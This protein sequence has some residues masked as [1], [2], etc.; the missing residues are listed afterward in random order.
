MTTSSTNEIIFQ[1]FQ[2]LLERPV[3]KNEIT[4]RYAIKSSTFDK[5]IYI[6]KKAGFEI[7]RQKEYYNIKNY[8]QLIQ[9]SNFEKEILAYC[10]FL[11]FDLLPYSKSQAYINFL[12]KALLLCNKKEC[13][14]I[15]EKFNSFKIFSLNEEF[16]NKINTIQKYINENTIIKITITSKKELLITPLEFN[17]TKD[18]IYLNY[19]DSTKEKK[20]TIAIEK[21]VKISSKNE[22]EIGIS[23][24]E[25]IFELYGKL[26]KSYLLREDERIVDKLKDK[27]VV[28]NSDTDKNILF[29]RLLRYDT[30]C[31]VLF[32]KKDVIEFENLIKKSL[33]NIK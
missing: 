7:E 23:A 27:I 29:K 8:K 4:E 25:T 5:Y 20:G 33:D 2:N 3:S 30:Y 13:T 16:K 28:A 18:K 31:K 32:P 19:F 14:N 12:K 9:L 26:A 11:A 6:F 24:N 17:W 21:I 10:G 1:I 15:F 22:K